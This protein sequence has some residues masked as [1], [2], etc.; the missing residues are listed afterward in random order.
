MAQLG[1]NTGT[2]LTN[3]IANYLTQQKQAAN[4]AVDTTQLA[5]IINNLFPCCKYPAF[6]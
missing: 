6:W 1:S 4:G 5:T 2:Q 3:D